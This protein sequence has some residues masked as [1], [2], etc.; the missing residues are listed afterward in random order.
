MDETGVEIAQMQSLAR[1]EGKKIP[2]YLF[3]VL[4]KYTNLFSKMIVLYLRIQI[5]RK[6]SFPVS[7]H[8]WLLG[9]KNITEFVQISSFGCCLHLSKAATKKNNKIGGLYFP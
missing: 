7:R 1:G 9:N 6:L 8:L 2:A 3:I 5:K 4:S